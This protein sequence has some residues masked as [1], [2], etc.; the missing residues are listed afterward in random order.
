MYKCDHCNYTSNKLNNVNLHSNIKHRDIILEDDNEKEENECNECN[1]IFS[2]KYNLKRH[3]ETCKGIINP[4]QCQKCKKIFSTASSKCRHTKTCKAEVKE[5]ITPTIINNNIT[6]N[7]TNNNTTNNNNII[8]NTYIFHSDPNVHPLA[9]QNY[10]M[11]QLS[12]NIIIP[13][14]NNLPLMIEDFGRLLYNDHH[15][16]NIKKT[17]N[18]NKYC[19]VKNEKGEWCNKLDK[20]IIPKATKDIAYNFRITID[21]NEIELCNIDKKNKSILPK[22]TEFLS[23]IIDYNFELEILN[24]TDKED[25]KLFND[26]KDR[27]ICIILDSSK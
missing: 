19:L 13:N 9:Y 14:K 24:D 23:I 25:D 15:N 11:Q 4:S 12:N 10:N 16:K 27:T 20:D 22:L 1:K 8:N 7:T 26:M 6:N 5:D 17:S 3:Q 21:N 18:K 2:T